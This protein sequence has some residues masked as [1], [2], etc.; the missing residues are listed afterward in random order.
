MKI[1]PARATFFHAKRRT[2]K[3]YKAYSR[4]SLCKRA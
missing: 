2:D 1:R 3:Y 4:Y